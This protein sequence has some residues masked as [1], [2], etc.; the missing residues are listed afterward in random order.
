VA[1]V[2]DVSDIYDDGGYAALPVTGNGFDGFYAAFEF[3]GAFAIGFGPRTG[4][5]E[6]IGGTFRA[7]SLE[8]AATRGSLFRLARPG[9]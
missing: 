3:G 4:A 5:G 8:P 1:A 2:P 7:P 6:I 9:A